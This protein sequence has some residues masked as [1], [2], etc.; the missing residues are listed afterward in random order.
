M[1]AGSGKSGLWTRLVQF[2]QAG[3]HGLAFRPLDFLAKHFILAQ[4]DLL[5]PT[6]LRDSCP[7]E[8]AIWHFLYQTHSTTETLS[9][10]LN[11]VIKSVH[12]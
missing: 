3:A 2:R 8:H 4:T 10:L 7:L 12:S 1:A 9:G 5:L 6:S 11:P